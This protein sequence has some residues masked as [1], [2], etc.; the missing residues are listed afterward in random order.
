MSDN[1]AALS[2]QELQARL[3]TLKA[4]MRPVVGLVNQIIAEATPDPAA[5]II[6]GGEDDRHIALGQYYK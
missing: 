3:D 5:L 4:E 2:E 6:A 1:L